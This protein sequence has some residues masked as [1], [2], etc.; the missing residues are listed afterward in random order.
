MPI[1]GQFVCDHIFY[2]FTVSLTTHLRSNVL[3]LEI[4]FYNT[5]IYLFIVIARKTATTS[6]NLYIKI[7]Y[8]YQTNHDFVKK[9]LNMFLV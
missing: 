8:Y 4:L 1:R 6:T 3:E 9:E 7:F 5:F 2:L